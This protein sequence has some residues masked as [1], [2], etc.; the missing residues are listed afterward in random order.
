MTPARY[1]VQRERPDGTRFGPI[2]YSD[3]QCRARCGVKTVRGWITLT[4]DGTGKATCKKCRK[5]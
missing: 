3:S 4:N 2:H 1:T 5:V